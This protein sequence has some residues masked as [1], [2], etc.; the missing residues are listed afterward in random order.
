MSS[1][2]SLKKPETIKQ[3]FFCASVNIYPIGAAK[4]HQS[5]IL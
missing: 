1:T 2:E 4:G 5:G 3:F